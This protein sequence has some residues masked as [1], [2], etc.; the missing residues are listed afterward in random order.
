MTH[1]NC[2]DVIQCGR[3]HNGEEV[4]ELG[5][6]PAAM[7]S[8]YDGING[9]VQGGR[10]CWAIS[11]TF[12]GRKKQSTF[13]KKLIGCMNCTF[14]KQVKEDEGNNFILSPEHHTKS[15]NVKA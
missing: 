7:T 5:V 9:G 6:C 11:G 13:T 12:C 2:W 4:N 8:A 3:Q 10:F 15:P 14:L 1:Q